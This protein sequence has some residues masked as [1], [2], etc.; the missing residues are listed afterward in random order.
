MYNQNVN[1]YFFLEKI[2][3]LWYYL[4]WAYYQEYLNIRILNNLIVMTELFHTYWIEE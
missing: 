3:T 4:H 2:F 1:E